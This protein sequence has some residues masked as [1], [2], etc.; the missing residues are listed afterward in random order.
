MMED[1]YGDRPSSIYDEIDTVEFAT[2][3]R[4]RERIAERLRAMRD[5]HDSGPGEAAV[6]AA[7]IDV[8]LEEGEQ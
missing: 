8:T 6:T 2:T 4:E 3:D 7:M 1:R 5:A